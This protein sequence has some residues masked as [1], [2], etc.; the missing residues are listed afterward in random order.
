MIALSAADA[1]VINERG[2][3]ETRYFDAE[4]LRELVGSLWEKVTSNKWKVLEAGISFNNLFP[5]GAGT[6]DG[7][8][9]L[10]LRHCYCIEKTSADMD[11]FIVATES[12]QEA[13]EN[14]KSLCFTCNKMIPKDSS[15]RRLHIGKHILK[16][17]RNVS[18]TPAPVHTVSLSRYCVVLQSNVERRLIIFLVGHVANQPLRGTAQ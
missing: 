16:V 3:V 18:E 15:K 10:H 17:L 8:L 1:K 5:Y 12:I 9:S 7:L 2:L 14:Q 11:R 13:R 4:Y 6:Q